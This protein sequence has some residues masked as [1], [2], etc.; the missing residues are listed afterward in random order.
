MD[1]Y[2]AL[3]CA[4]H[5]TPIFAK[6]QGCDKKRVWFR[7]LFKDEFDIKKKLHSYLKIHAVG[8]RHLPCISTYL[9]PIYK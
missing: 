7:N 9:C 5:L 2:S 3:G 8:L 1:I 6:L 4:D